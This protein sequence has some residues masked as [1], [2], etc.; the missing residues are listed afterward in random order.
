[1]SARYD[2]SVWGDC[3]PSM[4]AA[5]LIPI[6]CKQLVYVNA[7]DWS[8]NVD[9]PI[10]C[11]LYGLPPPNNP[12]DGCVNYTFRCVN[13]VFQRSRWVNYKKPIG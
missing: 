10:A 5:P 11:A 13:Y 8:C 4:L 3:N 7:K 2:R 9:T 12:V 6:N 1:M